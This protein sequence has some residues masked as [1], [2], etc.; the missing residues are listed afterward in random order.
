M[1]TFLMFGNYSA[2]SIR[3]VSEQRTRHVMELVKETGGEILAMY[4]LL[5]AFDLVVVIKLPRFE[6]AANLS[7]LMSQSLGITFSTM[8]AIPVREF[9]EL[10]KGSSQ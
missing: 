3:S 5:G 8:P 6:D 1:S 9:E 4:A 2:D 10:T 7:M